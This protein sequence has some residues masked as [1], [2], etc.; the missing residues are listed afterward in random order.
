[1]ARLRWTAHARDDLQS[2]A[3]HI[4]RDSP[5]AAMATVERLLSSANRLALFPESGRVC[6]EFREGP[7]REVV[8]GQYRVI[9]RLDGEIVYVTAVVHAARQLRTDL[10]E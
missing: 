10:M 8:S 9:Y 3:E 2:I 1:M 5:Q 7:Y 4:R 6:P